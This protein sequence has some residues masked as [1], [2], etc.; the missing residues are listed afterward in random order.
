MKRFVTAVTA[1]LLVSSVG[2]VLAQDAKRIEAGRLLFSQK[3][4][5]KCHQIAGRGNKEHPLDHVATKMNE[6]DIRKWL[7]SPKEMEATLEKQ[8]KLKMSSK[9]INLSAA[10]IDQLMA[11]L[12]TLK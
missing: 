8:P 7:T 3:E 2:I 5:T 9:K 11:Y 4:C 10:Q 6:T 12:L 1:G